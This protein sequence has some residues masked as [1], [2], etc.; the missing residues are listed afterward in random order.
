LLGSQVESFARLS[1]LLLLDY[2]QISLHARKL[3]SIVTNSP[4]RSVSSMTPHRHDVLAAKVLSSSPESISESDPLSLS[5]SLSLSVSLNLTGS[6]RLCSR[7]ANLALSPSHSN[8]SYPS[9]K[10]YERQ[11]QYSTIAIPSFISNNMMA[12]QIPFISTYICA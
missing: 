6:F 11:L 3:S 2:S 12:P 5:L 9:P 4:E 1:I 8:R 7:H 10:S